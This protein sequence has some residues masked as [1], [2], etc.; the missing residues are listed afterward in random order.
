MTRSLIIL[1]TVLFSITINISNTSL[2]K[3]WINQGDEWL[4]ISGGVFIG[5]INSTLSVDSSSL[6]AGA[7]VDLEN[8]LDL[9]ENV[10]T[11]WG[12]VA[13]RFSKKHRLSVGY[14]QFDRDA[15]ATAKE[16]LQIGDEIYPAGA[17]IST[18]FKIGVLPIT[19]TYSFMNKKKYEFGG[20]IGLHWSTLY[21]DA[22]GSAS[23]SDLDVDAN[24]SADAAAPMP[25]I[26]LLYDYHFT[27]KWTVGAHGELF[28]L[29]IKDNTFAFSGT[30]TNL[31]LHTDYWVF[32]NLGLG[33]AVN[34]FALDVEVDD[35]DWKGDLDY[36][37]LGLQVFAS[38]RF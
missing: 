21:F 35:S 12:N 15:S 37:Y 29:D 5:T 26:G 28:F 20:T 16:D 18:E 9:G 25:L 3:E 38:I 22:A 11:Y 31:R 10:T 14:F 27:P 34:W 13:W 2:A 7:D 17:S 36:Q 4:K 32:N 30:I 33:A 8:D 24:I 19:Y 1:L 23:L 6:G